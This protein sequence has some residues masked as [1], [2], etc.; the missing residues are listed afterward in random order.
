MAVGEV[1]QLR[2]PSPRARAPTVD[3]DE[4]GARSDVLVIELCVVDRHQWHALT[5][6]P[7][8][9]LNNGQFARKLITDCDQ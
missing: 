6:A 5:T 9:R 3:E 1:R 2:I 8:S 4:R 7:P